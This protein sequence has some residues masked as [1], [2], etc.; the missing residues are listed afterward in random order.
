MIAIYMS[1]VLRYMVKHMN[2]IVI[3]MSEVVQPKPFTSKKFGV[4]LEKEIDNPEKVKEI[5]EEMFREAREAIEKQKNGN[6][7]KTVQA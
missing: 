6:N 3:E 4:T 7:D 5:M 2:R 1:V